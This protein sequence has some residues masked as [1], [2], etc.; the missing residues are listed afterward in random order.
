MLKKKDGLEDTGAARE[1]TVR[2]FNSAEFTFIRTDT[3]TQEILQPP[4][5]GTDQNLLSPKPSVRSP[6]RSLD[7]F[8]SSRSR[9]A[10]VSSQASHSSSSKR[11]LSERLHI[12]RQPESSEYVPE[13]LP[14]ITA[15]DPTDQSEWEKRATIL[16]GQNVLARSRPES[17]VSAAAAAS[18]PPPPVQGVAHMS[19]G[20][21]RRRSP[22]PT[23]TSSKA[24]DQDIQDAIRLHEEGNFE[25]STKI[26]GRLADLQGANNP[27]SQVLYGLAL[28]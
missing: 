11:R 5:D 9:S 10:S 28:R 15:N 18:P 20:G 22:S 19:L 8:R 16:A 26:F 17:P 21:S 24:I 13:N 2:E 25:Q 12:S 7:V 14:A 4:G 27:L 1:E 23:P 6:R 3:T